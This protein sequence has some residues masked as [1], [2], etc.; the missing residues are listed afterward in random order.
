MN[1]FKI[2]LD[3][4]NY[5][6]SMK[7][8][9]GLL[10]VGAVSSIDSI[11]ENFAPAVYIVNTMN[12]PSSAIG[13]VESYDVQ[14]WTIVVAVSHEGSQEDVLQIMQES[15]ELINK[16][17]DAVTRF[18]PSD[19]DYFEPMKRVRTSGRPFY[20]STVG[21]YPFTFETKFSPAI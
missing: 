1:Y 3:L 14:Q 21:L 18:K 8:E 15:G 11:S 6:E 17:L 7:E 5:F 9:L 20:Y 4:I 2:G 13:G 16:V 12:D 10:Q 19:S